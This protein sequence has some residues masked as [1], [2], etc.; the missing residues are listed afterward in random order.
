MMKKLA[1]VVITT[2]IMLTAAGCTSKSAGSREVKKETST[3]EKVL[4]KKKLAVGTAPGYLPFDLCVVYR[5][6]YCLSGFILY[7]VSI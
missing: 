5:C 7:L 2:M 3:N 4:A 6:W 1:A